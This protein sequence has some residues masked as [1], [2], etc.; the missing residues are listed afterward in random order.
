[1][2]EHGLTEEQI[3]EF[4]EAFMTFDKDSDGVITAAE[5]GIVMRSLGQQPTEKEL[6][7]MVLMVDLD[8]NGT[9]EFHEFLF[10]MSKKIK[11][12]SREEALREAFAVF[13]RNSDG[14]ISSSDLRHAMINLGEKLTDEEVENMIKEAD[15]DGDGL[16]SFDEFVKIVTP[17]K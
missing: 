12:S 14:Y 9:I 7:N 15:S 2:I 4:K 5:L 13:D 1:M 6:R 8:G 10:M 17:A 11:D 16:V 3:A